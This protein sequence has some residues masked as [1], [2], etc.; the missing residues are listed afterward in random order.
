MKLEEGESIADVS[1]C[2]DNDDVLLSTA[3]GQCIRFPV[4]D[5]RVFQSRNS[6]GVRGIRLGDSDRVISMAIIRHVVA[7]SEERAAYLRLAN[8][9]RR[10]DEAEE[11]GDDEEKVDAIELS[12]T[13]YAEMGAA[14]QFI[15]TLTERG[16][17]KRTSSFE[18]RITGRG[19][20]GIVA[21][22]VNKRNGN[23]VG[24]F[25]VEEADEIMLVTD[26][27]KLIRTPVDGIRIAGR[28]TQGVI[29]FSTA[30][31][32]KVVSVER[33]SEEA[34]AADGAK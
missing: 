30:E 13:R 9:V 18:Y 4:A 3:A 7:S 15:L 33:I 26:G 2:S 10:G 11:A 25:P 14:E 31:D 8:A 6:V 23:V 27:G 17:G 21:M 12:Q 28:S 29:V 34:E 1:I 5:V 24:S 19:G 16:F 22:K 20:K 32:E